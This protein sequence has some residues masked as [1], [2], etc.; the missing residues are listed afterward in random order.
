MPRQTAKHPMA[1]AR[2][3]RGGATSY[4]WSGFAQVRD[5]RKLVVRL[6]TAF[7][8]FTLSWHIFRLGSINLTISDLALIA[9]LGLLLTRGNLNVLP[10]GRMTNLWFIGLVMMLGALLVSS[11]VSGDPTRWLVVGGQYIF[12]YLLLPMIVASNDQAWIRRYL[13]CFVLGVTASQAIAITASFFFTF[14]DTQALMGWDFLTGTGRI[15]AF[16]GN[17]NAN[18]AMV[19][20]ALPILVNA[21]HHRTISLKLALPCAVILIWGLLSSASFTAFSAAMLALVIVYLV[22]NPLKFL[23]FGLPVAVLTGAFLATDPPLPAAFQNR[24]AGALESGNLD[25]AGSYVGRASLNAEAWDIANDTILIGLGV[26]GFRKVSSNGAPVH[27]FPLIVLTEGGFVALTGLLMLIGVL[28]LAALHAVR[29]NRHDGAM[30]M[31][32]LA[33][34]CAFTIAVPHMFSRLW[35]GPVILVLAVSFARNSHDPA[36]AGRTRFRTR[37][38]SALRGKDRHPASRAEI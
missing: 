21:L 33:V 34:Y 31:A 11:L 6:L 17:A 30:A 13:V 5:R 19:G 24:V 36:V 38:P 18:G 15:G 29:V 12:G 8:A 3:A 37:G 9:S 16:S 22:A 23:Q 25:E 4:S 7:A 32:V 28:L 26:D 14:D 27:N 2:P 35:I 10:F 20:F 1:S